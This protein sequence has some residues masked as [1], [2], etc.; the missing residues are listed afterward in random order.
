MLLSNVQYYQLLVV[1]YKLLRSQVPDSKFDAE[2]VTYASLVE[3]IQS[4]YTKKQSIIVHRFNFN[5]R[6]RKIDESIAEY[7]AA[8]RELALTCKFEMKELLEG[9]IR[10]HFVSAVNHPGIQ[11]KLLSEDDLTY[12]DAITS[13]DY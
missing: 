12:N 6:S 4:H 10:D 7:I 11:H 9:M 13:P 5:C 8:L 1:T 3:L 2:G